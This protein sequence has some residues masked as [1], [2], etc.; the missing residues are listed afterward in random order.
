MYKIFFYNNI[1]NIFYKIKLNNLLKII[2]KVG[3]GNL[4][5][6]R[7]LNALLWSGRRGLIIIGKLYF[8]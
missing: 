2:Y 4:K 8:I 6:P 5:D 3:L 1:F 7:K